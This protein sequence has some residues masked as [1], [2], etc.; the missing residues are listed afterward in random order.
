MM[1]TTQVPPRCTRCD[2]P[3]IESFPVPNRGGAGNHSRRA[4]RELTA[5]ALEGVRC[6]MLRPGELRDV[7]RILREHRRAQ[8]VG[9]E[10]LAEDP[11]PLLVDSS[12]LGNER[13]SAASPAHRPSTVR[14]A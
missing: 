3:A 13:G 1:A 10:S 14:R 2:R 9:V 6:R 7:A 4:V 5:I 8:D 12:I 11:L